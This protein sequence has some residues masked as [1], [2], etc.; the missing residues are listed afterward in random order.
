MKLLRDFKY[1]VVIFLTYC[2][3]S[4]IFSLF[5][6]YSNG[7]VTFSDK[8]HL[9]CVDSIYF[10]V[11]T[12]TTLGYGDIL[13]QND[14]Y[15]LLISLEVILGIAIFGLFISSLWSSYE[16]MNNRKTIKRDIK[17]LKSKMDDYKISIF[18]LSDTNTSKIKKNDPKDIILN[19]KI[20]FSDLANMILPIMDDRH[21]HNNPML[22]MRINVFSENEKKLL[23]QLNNFQLKWSHIETYKLSE[24]INEY[25]YTTDIYNN[26]E[27][28]LVNMYNPKIQHFEQ[29]YLTAMV[30]Y[31]SENDERPE[32]FNFPEL[33]SFY[34]GVIKRIDKFTMLEKE[35]SY[36]E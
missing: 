34:D 8:S 36:Y 28:I 20:K 27:A 35:V 32:D 2:T 17:I 11:V 25:I 4:F 29:P 1:S 6:Y 16:N 15:K 33:T 19:K 26:T 3:V 10:S 23:H 9:S 30:K 13:P 31:F 7:G 18:S 14:F 24:S 21:F 12:I 5:Y 22:M